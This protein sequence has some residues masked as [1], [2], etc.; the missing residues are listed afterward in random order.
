MSMPTRDMGLRSQDRIR[1]F[2]MRL[3]QLCL[4]TLALSV[5]W[6]KTPDLELIRSSSIY[7]KNAERIAYHEVLRS[8]GQF[9]G[10]WVPTPAL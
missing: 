2:V 8:M 9:P 1:A 5:Q 4:Y 10:R 3:G 7:D 6:Q